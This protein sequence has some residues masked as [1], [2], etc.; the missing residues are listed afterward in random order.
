M[1]LTIHESLVQ[2]QIS[3]YPHPPY[4]SNL[5]PTEFWLFRRIR[6]KKKKEH[7]REMFCHDWVEKIKKAVTGTLDEMHQQPWG[8]FQGILNFI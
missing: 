2:K 5:A 8:L 6:K 4:L 1:S 7:E 3:V